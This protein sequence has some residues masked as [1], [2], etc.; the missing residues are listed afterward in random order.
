[1]TDSL[2]MICFVEYSMGLCQS[3]RNL[4]FSFMIDEY[5]HI[6]IYIILYRWLNEFIHLKSHIHLL[7]EKLNSNVTRKLVLHLHN[8]NVVKWKFFGAHMTC[9]CLCLWAMQNLAPP[10]TKTNEVIEK[11]LGEMHFN[12]LIARRYENFSFESFLFLRFYSYIQS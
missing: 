9:R 10:L 3:W 4:Q 2:C 5:I 1:M 8:G 6:S 11:V 7:V 12:R